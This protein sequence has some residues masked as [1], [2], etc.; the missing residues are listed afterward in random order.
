MKE[1]AKQAGPEPGEMFSIAGEKRELFAKVIEFFPYPVQVFSEDGTVRMV[2]KATL[3]IIGIKSLESHIGKYNVFQDPIV[4]AMGATE[5]VRDVLKGKTVYLTDFNAPYPDLV[6]YFDVRDRDIQTISADITCFPVIKTGEKVEY[7]AAV[8]Y[9]KKIYRGKEEI[10]W[11][12][13]YIESHWL[14][15]F[16]ADAVAKAAYLSKAHFAKLFRKHTGMTPYEYYINCKIN[17]LKEK[18]LDANLSVKQAFAQC[19]MDYN[20]HSARIFK[21][22]VGL[23]PS[24]YRK[25]VQGKG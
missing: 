10:G 11:G 22:K 23:S 21:Q 24:A 9:I 3:D 12:K 14:E 8:F 7:F 16:D 13:Q 1:Q 4:K 18:L 20:G 25:A 19:N 15:P 5:K 17:K 6:R 2:N